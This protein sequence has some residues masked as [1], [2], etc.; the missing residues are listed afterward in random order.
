MAL[1]ALALLAVVAANPFSTRAST[2]DVQD[3]QQTPERLSADVNTPSQVGQ[4][5][6]LGQLQA[7]EE[8]AETT[9]P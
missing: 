1:G 9:K 7:T 5:D 4:P 2:T 6:Q 8:D 3:A